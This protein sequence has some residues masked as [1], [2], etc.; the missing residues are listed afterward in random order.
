MGVDFGGFD[1]GHILGMNFCIKKPGKAH[2]PL[3]IALFG[4]VRIMVLSENLSNLAM[5]FESGL[6][7]NF[8][9]YFIR[10]FYSI[11]K[12]KNQGDIF[13]CYHC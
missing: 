8:G 10:T 3:A 7:R 11:N 1:V 13:H 6:W 5:S 9:L 4:V 12:W 2:G